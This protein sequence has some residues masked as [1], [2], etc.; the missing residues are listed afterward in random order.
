MQQDLN[1]QFPSLRRDEFRPK[2]RK[3]EIRKDNDRKLKNHVFGLVEKEFYIHK[4]LTVSLEWILGICTSQR[5]CFGCRRWW[6]KL[7]RWL[8]FGCFVF[9]RS[10]DFWLIVCRSRFVSL[11]S[12][13]RSP[14]FLRLDLIS[15]GI[16]WLFWF[17]L[18]PFAFPSTDSMS[19][20]FAFVVLWVHTE[21]GIDH[22]DNP[23]DQTIFLVFP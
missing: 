23:F 14:K 16:D 1:R 5:Q 10:V 21:F 2:L 19:D 9:F 20:R 22:L 4:D 7:M 13:S 18:R 8:S 15:S 17:L 3:E 11:L 6:V 12:L